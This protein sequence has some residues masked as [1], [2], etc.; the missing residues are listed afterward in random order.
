MIT[1]EMMKE[2]VKRLTAQRDQSLAV[3]HQT[4]GALSLAEHLI[5]ELEKGDEPAMTIEEL[6]AALQAEGAEIVNLKAHQ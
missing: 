4:V 2:Q 6:G 1:V 5:A 3:Y